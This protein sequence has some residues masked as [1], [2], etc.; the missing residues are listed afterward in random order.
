MSDQMLYGGSQV[1]TILG[2]SVDKM[3]IRNAYSLFGVGSYRKLLPG[4]NAPDLE[5]RDL[6]PH[7]THGAAAALNGI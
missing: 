4:L 6:E 5:P 1:I 7:S 3:A 2:E